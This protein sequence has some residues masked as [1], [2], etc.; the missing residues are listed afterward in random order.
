MLSRRD[1][2]A[3]FG[4]T[5]LGSLL[6]VRSP[7]GETP[8]A[9]RQWPWVTP[10]I[11][12]PGLQQIVFESA[13]A[14]TD[15]SFHVLSPPAVTTEPKRLFPTLYW[16]HGT[17]GAIA[18]I[19]PVAALFAQAMQD[20]RMPQ[21]FVVF[22]NGLRDSLWCDARDGSTPVE[23]ILMREIIPIVDDRLRTIN[24]R[25]H[26]TIEGFSMGG[27]GAGHLGFRYPETFAAISMLGAGPL[28]VAF[29]SASVVPTNR[30]LQAELFARI[31]GSDQDYFRAE[32]PRG[33][34]TANAARLRNGMRIRIAIGS[35]DF[36]LA[37]NRDFS[38]FLFALGIQHDLTI[39]PGVGHHALTLFGALGFDFHRSVFSA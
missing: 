20:G 12:A 32:S 11:V 17:A 37:A 19:R 5:A 7:L 9:G 36:T 39:V 28:Q 6:R 33:L 13:V 21:A 34:A 29:T 27:F 2:V 22:P 31:F 18:S 26:R 23:S 14:R 30:P 4:T 24:D 3:G 1:L 38:A 16:L 35:D 25:A 15:V 10:A 8:S